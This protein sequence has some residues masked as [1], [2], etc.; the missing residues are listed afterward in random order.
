MLTDTAP[1]VGIQYCGVGWAM[2]HPLL[3]LQLYQYYGNRN[4]I[5]EQYETS[6]KWLDLVIEQYP[7][8]IVTDGLSDH[9]SLNPTPSPLL[10]TPLFYQSAKMLTKL[11]A[12]LAKEE[13]T[14][15][16]QELTDKIKEAYLESFLDPENGTIGPGTQTSQLFTLFSQLVLQDEKGI[17][18][19]ILLDDII[20]KNNGHLTTG[21]MGTKF[22]LDVL[23][24]E[25]YPDVAYKIANQKSF[26]GW[27]FMLEN[28]ATT[29]WEHWE[30]SDNTYSHNH[31]MFGSVSQ[32]FYKW[33]GG[34]QPHPDAIGFDQII[35][36]PQFIED[37]EWVNCSYNSIR[38]QIVSNWQQNE[39]EIKLE[40]QIP[41]GAEA[42]I[43]LPAENEESLFEHGKL[44]SNVKNIYFQGKIDSS[45]IYRVSSGKYSFKIKK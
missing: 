5:E 40:I 43:Y 32:W 3:Q 31:P 12:I 18:L 8:F 29:L 17:V 22:L 42:S 28:D 39:K 23:S 19:K 25:N 30:F 15:K 1:F 36:R 41:V 35:I 44:I 37:L 24:R 7:D 38:G 9:E 16:Y 2:V 10:V 13:E 21:I 14:K 11:S 20:N 27:G 26:P 6:K 33:L 34:I 4:I 45:F